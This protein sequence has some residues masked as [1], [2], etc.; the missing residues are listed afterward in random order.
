MKSIT[1]LEAINVRRSRRKYCA[2]PVDVAMIEKLEA[3]A[4]EYCSNAGIRMELV[5]NDG[6]A[7]NGLR[8]SYGMFSGVRN[9]VG[10]IA[11][12]DDFMTI[13]KLG[14]YG[15]LMTLHAVELGLSTCWVG[16][17]FSRK[18]CPFKLTDGEIVI[19]TITL[20]YAAEQDSGK[21]KFIRKLT[22]RK[23]KTAEEMMKS[24]A[25]ASDWFMNGMRM[26]PKAP[27]AV[28]RQPVVFS[29]CDGKV[30]AEIQKPTDIGTLLDLGIAK[31]HFELGAGNGK[32]NFGNGAEFIR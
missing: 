29:Y 1:L 2:T 32:W 22:H 8:K 23:T 17:S 12:K 30:T 28:N 10:L 13:E 19:C 27:S 25:P 15:E 3:L 20:G 16:G 31:L 18:M 6:S 21:E 14:Y 26:I 4:Q 11:K 7:F 9:Y 5:W 24:D